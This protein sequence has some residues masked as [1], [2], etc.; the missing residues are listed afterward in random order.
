MKKKHILFWLS[1]LVEDGIPQHD[2][3]VGDVSILMPDVL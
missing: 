2:R 3:K 1:H